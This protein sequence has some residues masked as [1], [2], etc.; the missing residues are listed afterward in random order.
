MQTYWLISSGHWQAIRADIGASFAAL[1]KKAKRE[2]YLLGDSDTLMCLG[3]Y[4]RVYVYPE[5]GGKVR[6]Y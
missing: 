3:G 6:L 1:I 4:T 5:S 2:A